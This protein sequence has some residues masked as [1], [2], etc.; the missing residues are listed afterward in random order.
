[1]H[2]P[3][4][5]KDGFW[6]SVAKVTDWLNTRIKNI[7][8]FDEH[9][10]NEAKTNPFY[11]IGPI[12]YL[13]WFIT[14]ATGL[15]L[16]MWYVPSKAVAFDS[17]LDIQTK[18]PFGNLM[19]G[20][21]K[22]GA[23]AM[24]IAATIRVFRM[25]IMA[26]YKPGKELNIAIGLVMLLL[27]MY[28]GLSGYLLIWNQRA[29]WATKVFATFP[30]Y[31]DQFPVM[32]DYYEPLVK[33]LHL[34]WNTAEVLLGAGGAITQETIT[35]FFSL[36]L[37][38]S[39]IPLILVEIYFYNNNYKRI[40]LNWVKRIVVTMMLVITSIV[41][42][43]AQGRRSDPDV[44]PLPIL[45]DWYFLGLYQMYKYLE[46]VVATEIT[47]VIPV[48]VILLPFL[49]TYIS[50]PSEKSLMKRPFIFMMTIMG[51]V[52][53]IVFSLLIIANIAN[54]HSD[55]PFWRAFM[56]LLIDVGI[57]WQLVLLWQQSDMKE[58]AKGVVPCVIMAL[59]GATQAFWGWVF[60]YMA[61]TEMFMSPLSQAA[62]YLLCRPFMGAD[63]Q[64]T[65]ELIQALVPKGA[66]M[67]YNTDFIVAVQTRWLAKVPNGEALLNQ[68]KEIQTHKS[69]LDFIYQL[70]P[71]F[72]TEEPMYKGMMDFMISNKWA[73]DY[74]TFSNRM[75]KGTE[76]NYPLQVPEVDWWWMIAG[77]ITMVAAI[78]M[79]IECLNAKKL[80]P[81]PA[82][83]PAQSAVTTAPAA[84]P[85]APAAPAKAA[86]EKAEAKTEP[87]KEE[88]KSDS[89]EE[90]K[91]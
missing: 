90:K 50:G 66:Q 12:F 68:L 64:K 78:Y 69:P 38:F 77:V 32:G 15:I 5:K 10:Q 56:Y 21:H 71:T 76:A 52:T 33:S 58:K 39:L 48:S 84:K 31:M 16:I 41:L 3:A 27:S 74:V 57:I 1:M 7:D 8:I 79:L 51:G 18:V 42:P 13:V 73:W 28:S 61:R 37:A 35:R 54:I 55:P 36:H 17:I 9:Y 34:G 63:A 43:A 86:E 19:R 44:T 20:V 88:P 70:V 80:V 87:P 6:G 40:P 83:K 67:P 89:G 14:M 26:D 25:F 72:N 82:A 81:A 65:E 2:S 45:S 60:Y 24:I 53:W 85:A 4:A 62:T 30:T 22:Y 91:D 29:F 49:D 75:T 23:D 47:M 46:P 59:I 11:A